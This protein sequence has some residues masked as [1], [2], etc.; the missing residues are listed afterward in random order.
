VSIAEDTELM[1]LASRI[2]DGEHVNWDVASS[3][4]VTGEARLDQLRALERISDAHRRLVSDTGLPFPA[5]GPLD[6]ER[7]VDRGG[8]GRIYLARDRNLDCNVALKLLNE[9]GQ[10]FS[11]TDFVKEARK[12]ASVR[13]ENVVAVHGVDRHEGRLGLWMEWIDGETLDEALRRGG[14]LAAREA[15]LVG[16]ELCRALA[17]V[18]A[19]GLVH[20]DVKLANVK[21]EQGGR[22]VL[23]DF[24]SATRSGSD[25]LLAALSG[26]PLYLPPEA[27]EG[28]DSGRSADIYALGVCLYRLVSGEYPLEPATAEE[29]RQA[30]RERRLVPLRD[31]NPNL[32]P[33][34]VGIVER[35]MSI[36]PG[37]RYH[38][39]GEMER[40]L[41]AFIGARRAPAPAQRTGRRQMLLAAAAAVVLALVTTFV[42]REVFGSFEPETAF[43][44]FNKEQGTEERLVDG[45][46][47][48]PG[49]SLLLEVRLDRRTWLY[50]LNADAAGEQNLLFPVE[51]LAFDNPV[52]KGT[53]R[54]PGIVN[55]EEQYWEITSAGGNETLL[56]VASRRPVD[57]IE[58]SIAGLKAVTPGSPIRIADATVGERLRGIGGMAPAPPD[59]PGS[60]GGPVEQIRSGVAVRAGEER[61]MRVW[62]LT[63]PNPE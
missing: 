9:D 63:L 54:I 1:K 12:L 59:E 22:I 44:R 40:E 55:A 38:S 57:F 7:L 3:E 60:Q 10:P 39:A 21:R 15:A 25:D 20:R 13:H 48:A 51:G 42:V 62:E 29:M 18:H 53:H 14:P 11:A 4:A 19:A 27:F 23:M 17:A 31:R 28:L 5:W 43:F 37:R 32:P 47:V 24:G 46:K 34:F 41:T 45:V 50:V 33:A 58:E 2:A 52:P 36:D 30:H 26:T 8:F 6:L 16:I 56:V 49:D 61:G 35:A